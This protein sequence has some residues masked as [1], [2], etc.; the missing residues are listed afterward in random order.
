MSK[1]MERIEAEVSN[2]NFHR[3]MQKQINEM[4][5]LINILPKKG[6]KEFKCQRIC[7]LNAIKDLDSCIEKTT[8]EDFIP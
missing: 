6:D 3:E 2:E 8:P 1:F 7:L 5:D 4:I